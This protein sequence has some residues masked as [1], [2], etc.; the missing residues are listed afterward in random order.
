MIWKICLLEELSEYS[1]K[2]NRER[3]KHIWVTSTSV[4][5]VKSLFVLAYFIATDD[6]NNEAGIKNNKRLFLLRGEINN[7]NVLT[8]GRNLYDQ[9]IND[10]IKQYYEIRKVSTGNGDD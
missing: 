7:Y 5:D 1:C 10:L 8:D 9:P 6:A 2:S 3:K 4:S